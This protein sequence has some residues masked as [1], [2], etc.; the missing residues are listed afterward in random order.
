MNTPP[1]HYMRNGIDDKVAHNIATRFKSIEK[2]SGKL[3][4]DVNEHIENYLDAANV[5]GLENAKKLQFFHNIFEGEAR[6]F[7]RQNVMGI[8]Q[9]FVEACT[10]MR[11]EYNSIT[12]QNRV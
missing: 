1:P 4:E 8:S 11:E 3:G 12:R 9:S 2:F 5:Y 10:R 6:R 7:Y